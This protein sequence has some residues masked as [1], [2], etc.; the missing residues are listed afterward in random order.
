MM[1]FH[2]DKC[3]VITISRKRNPVQYSY[4][5]NGHQLKHYVAKYLGVQISHDL[6]WDKHI[7]YITS[8]ANSTLGFLRRNINIRNPQ[9]KEHS[10]KTLVRP[11][12]EY[13]QSVCDPY[14]TG[15]VK[16]V[17]SVQ[18]RAARYTLNRYSRTSSVSSMLSQLNWQPLAERRRHARLVMFYKIHYQLVSIR[19]PLTLKFHPQPTRTENMFAYNIPSS[20]CDYHLQSYFPRTVRD[21][22]TLPQE[23]V[24][25]DTVEAF[26]RA[27]L[28][29]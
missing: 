28:T 13:S 12:L 9:I 1:E 18:R 17:E 10:Y 27:L 26:R 23:L 16:K 15:A 21:W 3:E 7:D 4:T 11:I 19:I 20:N 6:R 5:L 24:Q 2:P 25:L 8:K 22:N 14:T 29:I